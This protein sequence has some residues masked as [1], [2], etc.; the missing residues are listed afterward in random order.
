MPL[1]GEGLG[2]SR[3]DMDC[4]RRLPQKLTNPRYNS[5]SLPSILSNARTNYC[6]Q[7][8]KGVP[9]E[10]A[11]FAYAKLLDNLHQLGSPAAALRMASQKAG[12]IVT[13][14]G[15]FIID[16]PFPP[17]IMSDPYTVRSSCIIENHTGN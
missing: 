1:A 8:K 13:D 11:P 17:E 7:Y 6:L 10:V 14:N 5:A 4:R 15:N 12:P 16:A 3:Y 2:G 9:V